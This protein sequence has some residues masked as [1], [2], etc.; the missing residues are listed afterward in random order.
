MLDGS[1]F[2]AVV[3]GIEGG[4]ALVEMTLSS[5]N[6]LAT[7]HHKLIPNPAATTMP[8]SRMVRVISLPCRGRSMLSLRVAMRFMWSQ[9]GF[10]RGVVEGTR[11]SMF[12]KERF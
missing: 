5:G 6:E 8:T 10:V 4:C 3:G 9:R 2:G 11:E 12:C 7:S 1:G